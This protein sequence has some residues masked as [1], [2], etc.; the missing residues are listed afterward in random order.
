VTTVGGAIASVADWKEL[1]AKWSEVLANADLKYFHMKKFAHSVGPFANGWKDNEDRRQ[2]V[3]KEDYG[4]E[5]IFRPKF[6]ANQ[7]NL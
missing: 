5:P 4:K 6:R 7:V 2:D 3:I 1:D